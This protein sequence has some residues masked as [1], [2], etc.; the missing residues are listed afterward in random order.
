M[1]LA[2]D[3]EL[4]G[5]REEFRKPLAGTTLRST[6]DW[7]QTGATMDQALWARLGELGWVATAIAPEYGGSGVGELMLC[8]Q[9]EEV[10]RSLAP[11]PFVSSV[12]G[13][14]LAVSAAADAT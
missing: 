4:E 13:Y 3:A 1:K 6:L 11:V 5:L 8:L 14:G 2:F 10:G 7:L 9:A 12:C